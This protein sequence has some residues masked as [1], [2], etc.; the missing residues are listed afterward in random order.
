M[1]HL[2]ATFLLTTAAAS[3][4][5]AD[6]A[7]DWEAVLAART[8]APDAGTGLIRFDYAG[9]AASPDERAVL[10]GYIDHL[11]AAGE[12]EDAAA[13][14]AYW[15]NLYNAVT[16]DLVVENY[17][18]ESIKDIKSGL[19]SSGPWKRELIEVGGERL[20]LDDVEHGILRRRYPSPLIHYMVNCASVGC[21][22]LQPRLWRAETLDADRERAAREFVNSPRGARFEGGTLVVSSIYKWFEED[23]GGSRAGVVDHLR[24]YAAPELAARLDGVS[25]HGATDY[26]WSLNE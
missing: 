22:N 1:R 25:R 5:L 6:P 20:S 26:S 23:F 13:A 18:V 9:L 24:A 7:A 17:P 21:P 4:A 15:A 3:P 12:P 16:V 11:E 2:I 19:I 8:S 14:T 10:D